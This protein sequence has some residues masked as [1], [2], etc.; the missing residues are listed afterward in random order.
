MKHEREM[1]RLEGI[2]KRKEVGRYVEM[3]PRDK[4]KERT[5]RNG[6]GGSNECAVRGNI[7]NEGK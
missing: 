1:K 6:I 5:R 3:I 4:M 2:E 7:E